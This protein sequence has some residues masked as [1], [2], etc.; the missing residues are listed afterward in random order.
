MIRDK[1]NELEQVRIILISSRFFKCF[2]TTAISYMIWKKM[3][4]NFMYRYL[5]NIG[6]YINRVKCISVY[7]N[8]VSRYLIFNILLYTYIYSIQ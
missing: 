4:L 1:G 3:A 2:N 8:N 6:L 7:F 5:L